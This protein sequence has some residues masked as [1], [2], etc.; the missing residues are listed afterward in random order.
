MKKIWVFAEYVNCTLDRVALE[1]LTKAKELAAGLSGETEVAAVLLGS[2]A[3]SACKVLA[4]NIL[5]N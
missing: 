5:S 4:C 1:L 3:R 2:R